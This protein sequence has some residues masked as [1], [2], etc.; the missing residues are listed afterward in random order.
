VRLVAFYLTPYE[1]K[2]AAIAMKRIIS[3]TDAYVFGEVDEAGLQY[4]LQAFTSSMQ[5]VD[6][7][8]VPVEKMSFDKT[9]T[10]RYRVKIMGPLLEEWRSILV[11]VGITLTERLF[12][13]YYL[14]E[15]SPL[16]ASIAARLD[17]I[18]DIQL[19]ENDEK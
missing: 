13:Q 17:F 5:M 9:H 4:F 19:M 1:K 15:L 14:T 16:Q 8:A 3:I 12:E 11:H 10:N 7:T 2:C 18:G 6:D